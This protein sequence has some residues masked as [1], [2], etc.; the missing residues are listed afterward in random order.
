MPGS[1]LERNSKTNYNYTCHLQDIDD[2]PPTSCFEKGHICRG[3][4]SLWY[5]YCITGVIELLQQDFLEEK[6]WHIVFGMYQPK[7]N[8]CLLPDQTIATCNCNSDCT[9]KHYKCFKVE[10][11]CMIFCHGKKQSLSLLECKLISSH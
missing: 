4:F 8:L 1:S 11:T 10:E 5:K 9:R 7:K 2:L 3:A 6:G